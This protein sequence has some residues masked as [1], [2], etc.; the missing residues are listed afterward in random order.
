MD[1][2]DRERLTAL[3]HY[4]R[5][6]GDCDMDADASLVHDGLL[7]ALHHCKG[8]YD[9]DGRIAW[10]R[11]EIARLEAMEFHTNP[12]NA[13][14]REVQEQWVEATPTVAPDPAW[15]RTDKMRTIAGTPK[16]LEAFADM[17]PTKPG[18]RV[19]VEV[20][21]T[22][23][24]VT[25][26]WDTKP[27]TLDDFMAKQEVKQAE[28]DDKAYFDATHAAQYGP[29]LDRMKGEHDEQ[30]P[31]SRDLV[32][33]MVREATAHSLWPVFVNWDRGQSNGT[34][35]VYV[36]ADLDHLRQGHRYLV[37]RPADEMLGSMEGLMSAL[38]EAAEA[39]VRVNAEAC[40]ACNGTAKVR[41]FFFG[42]KACP[43]CEGTGVR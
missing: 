40:P 3:Q 13:P 24:G 28:A 29:H 25:M 17:E 20:G 14:K 5:R 1:P 19:V 12:D 4:V 16:L 43:D 27:Q 10:A 2:T 42:E 37:V 11:Q 7:I 6:N 35:K 39:V 41:G 18:D 26:S 38:S 31:A 9:M 15:D 34:G 21:T 36:M 32:E 22:G 33:R 8:G 30:Q 23:E